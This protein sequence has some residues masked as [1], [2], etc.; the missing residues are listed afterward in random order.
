MRTSNRCNAEFS[1]FRSLI[2]FPSL[3]GRPTNL[4]HALKVCQCL[5]L[6]QSIGV[7]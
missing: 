1:N 4:G 5:I 7:G 3:L 2:V 6:A